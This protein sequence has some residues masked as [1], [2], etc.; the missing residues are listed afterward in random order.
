VKIVFLVLALLFS[1]INL[2]A[3]PRLECEKKWGEAKF[4][5]KKIKRYRLRG[6]DFPQG[7]RFRLYVKWFN[8]EEAGTF[9]YVSNHRGY[10]ILDEELNEDPLYALCPLKRGERIAF[11]MRSEEDPSFSIETSVIPFPLEFKTDKGARI[12]LELKGQDGEAFLLQGSKFR[13]SESF[14]L[15]SS[16]QG[17][18]NRYCLMA[19]PDGTVTFPFIVDLDDLDGGECVMVIKR[20][21]EK[22]AI[23]FLI[24]RAALGLAGGF[25]LKIR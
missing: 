25:A 6:S 20:K 21:E 18:D 3:E 23:S 11:L 10:L 1:S 24:G 9:A 22:Y 16:F 5:G 14:E 7:D 19:S 4:K 12:S 2:F 15:H 8:G 17:K 13:P